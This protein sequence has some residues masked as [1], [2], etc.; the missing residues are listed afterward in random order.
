MKQS[1]EDFI[2]LFD[3]KGGDFLV[4]ILVICFVLSKIIKWAYLRTFK[5]TQQRR[6]HYEKNR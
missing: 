3:G 4:M 1:I 6:S 5:P 2:M